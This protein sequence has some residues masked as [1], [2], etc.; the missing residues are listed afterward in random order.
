MNK[1]AGVLPRQQI[2]S[3]QLRRL[4]VLIAEY[5]LK[6]WKNILTF[7]M[8]QSATLFMNVKGTEKCAAGGS[9]NNLQRTTRKTVW[10]HPSLISST[11]MI[12]VGISWSIS[13]LGM[14]LGCTSTLLRQKRNPW[15]GNIQG[16]PPSKNSRHQP[17]LGN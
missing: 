10:V 5:C 14:K 15:Y 11:L 6:S 3:L 13:F 8:A 7:H 12:I 2:L 17:A 4:C 9:L 16:L 1:G